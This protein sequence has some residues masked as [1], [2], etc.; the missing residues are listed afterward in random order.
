L[1]AVFG[2]S[3][4]RKVFSKVWQ[5]RE[6]AVT[7]IEN[8]IINEGKHNEAKAFV[9]GVGVARYTV[10]DKMAQVSQRSM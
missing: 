10:G 6:E 4:V 3:T 5:F 7:V 2:E 1:V 9:G 8:E